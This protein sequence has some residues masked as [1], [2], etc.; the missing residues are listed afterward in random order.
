MNPQTH[1][2]AIFRRIVERRA[3][4]SQKL[5]KHAV[6]KNPVRRANDMTARHQ[7]DDSIARIK[8]VWIVRHHVVAP[9]RNDPRMSKG[10][11]REPVSGGCSGFA[12]KFAVHMI[13]VAACRHYIASLTCHALQEVATWVI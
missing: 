7:P 5:V 8:T 1:A 2:A 10:L 9:R 12:N 3:Y 4:C 11:N 6:L 13:F